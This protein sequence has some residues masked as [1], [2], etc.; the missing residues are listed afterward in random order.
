MNSNGRDGYKRF[1]LYIVLVIVSILSI[2]S[3]FHF[4]YRGNVGVIKKMN[5]QNQHTF[6]GLHRSGWE[7]ALQSINELHDV[8]GVLFDGN[9]E[10]NFSWYYDRVIGENGVQPMEVAGVLPYRQRWVGFIHNPPNAPGWFDDSNQF[11]FKTK[12]FKESLKNCVGLWALSEYHAEW[13]RKELNIL[14]SVVYHPTDIDVPQFDYNK[15]LM[16]EDKKIYQ[17]GWWLRKLN[18]IYKLPID[19]VYRKIRLDPKT[20]NINLQVMYDKE[21]EIMKLE[22]EERYYKNTYRLNHLSN[23]EYDK[24]YTENITFVDLYDAS[25]NNAVIEAI[26]RATPILVNP[27]PAVVEY[28]G[29]DYPFYFV[30]LEEAARKALDMNLVLQTHNYLKESP[31]RKKITGEYFCKSIKNSEVFKKL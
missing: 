3:T 25:A 18:S 28:L 5:L 13:L 7:F 26:A 9:V 27:L 19:K 20:D 30:S 8:N 14:V 17:I 12:I 16:N 21:R 1:I 24:I 4:M 22:F 11:M 15:F 29:K 2:M 23:E 31:M 10:K 6:S